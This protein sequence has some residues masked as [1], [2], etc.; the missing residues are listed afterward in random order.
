M[1][2][3]HAD[4]IR[5]T[6]LLPLREIFTYMTTAI[7][8]EQALTIYW[9]LKKKSLYY[10]NITLF[11]LYTVLAVSSIHQFS[12]HHLSTQETSVHGKGTWSF[13]IKNVDTHTT[14]IVNNSIQWILSKSMLVS[15]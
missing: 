2:T 5:H 13:W 6:N 1:Y 3:S 14:H 8:K 9:P 12:I 10:I 4:C 15:Y 11:I 7:G